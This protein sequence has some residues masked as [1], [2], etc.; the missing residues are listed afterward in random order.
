MHFYVIMPKKTCS[1]D[2]KHLHESIV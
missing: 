1:D 2:I